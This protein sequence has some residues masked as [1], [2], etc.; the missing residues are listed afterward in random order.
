MCWVAGA[1]LRVRLP[2][3]AGQPRHQDLGESLQEEDRLPVSQQ[4]KQDGRQ[5][6]IC[7][8]TVQE[9]DRLTSIKLHISYST[10]ALM[11]IRI[12]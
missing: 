8:Q 9:E 7:K 12:F 6:E 5:E 4:E 1:Y 10:K 3:P 11:Q 2:E